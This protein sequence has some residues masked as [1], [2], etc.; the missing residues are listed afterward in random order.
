MDMRTINN[1]QSHEQD[2]TSE[3]SVAVKLPWVGKLGPSGLPGSHWLCR[4]G[5]AALPGGLLKHYGSQPC[6]MHALP[7]PAPSNHTL[8]FTCLPCLPACQIKN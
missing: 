6:P 3:S 4:T 8:P 1:T 2:K 5:S 7:L